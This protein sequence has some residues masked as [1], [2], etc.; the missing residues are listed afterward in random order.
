MTEKRYVVK[1]KWI[2]DSC[3]GRLL[4]IDFNTITDVNLCCDLLNRI[5][6]EKRDYVK[7]A[8]KLLEENEQLKQDKTN[9]RRAMSRDRVRYLNENE[10]LKAQLYCNS[11]GGVCSICKHCYLDEQSLYYISK[12]EKGHEKCQKEDLRYCDDFEL[13]GDLE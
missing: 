6:K 13:K 11:D 2:E 8:S 3:I 10:K 1:D 5:E 12:C 7:L 9:L 4:N